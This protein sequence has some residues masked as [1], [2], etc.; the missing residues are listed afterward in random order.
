MNGINISI[1]CLPYFSGGAHVLK[2]GQQSYHEFHPPNLTSTG[3]PL[4]HIP[5]EW[6]H[7]PPP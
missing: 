2:G 3:L 4:T 6:Y 7:R 1:V 5:I